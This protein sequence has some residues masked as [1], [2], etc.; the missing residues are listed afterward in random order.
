MRHTEFTTAE[1]PIIKMLEELGWEYI[2]SSELDR[3]YEEPF[4]RQTLRT[5][6]KKLNPLITSEEEVDRVI[7]ALRM[8]PN[9]ISG[10]EEFFKWIKG[11]KSLILKPGEKA[12][13]IRLIDFE[14]PEN[15]RF[16]VT[17][18]LWFQGHELV[19]F[20]IVLFINGLP[21]VVME[22]KSLTKEET[23]ET[24]PYEEALNQ[25]LRYHREAP[26]FMKYLAFVCPCNGVILKYGWDDPGKF[27]EW[28]DPKKESADP[29]KAAIQGLF[30]RKTFLDM[31]ENFIVFEKERNIIRKKIARYNQ[32]SAANQ[33][34]K[35][36]LEGKVKKGLI[37]HF[38]GS[39]KTLTMLF[40]AWKLKKIPQLS[41][42]A[43]LVVVDR[44]DLESQHLGTF[45][46]LPYTARADTRKHLREKLGRD[47]REII[48][49]TIQKFG[50]IERVLNRKENVII[51]IDEAHRSQYGALA[52]YM[53][54]ALPNAFIFGF[55]GTPIDKGPLGKSTFR[56]FGKH[57]DKY[58]MK[59]SI[60]DGATVPIYYLPKWM[61]YTTEKDR[62]E[63]DREFYKRTLGLS[64]DDQE[65][66][67][68]KSVR[69]KQILM[70]HD[71]IKKVA[72]DIAEHFK[73]NV[74]PLGFKAQ[75]VAV[76]REA[77]AL[78][79]DELDKHLPQ[80]WSV[81]IY[82]P[83]KN[84]PPFLKRFVKDQ[85]E[86]ERL[87]KEVAQGSFQRP[88]EN[89]RILIVTDMLLT[90]FD[91]PIEQ[92]MYLDKPMRDHRLLQAIA[93]TNRPYPHKLGG[94]VVDYV[95]VFE[96][97]IKVLNFHEED[98][99]DIEKA[100]CSVEEWK[101]EFKDKVSS[102]MS[103]FKDIEKKDYS[104]ST[105]F[106]AIHILEEKGKVKDFKETLSK[107]KE[108]YEN[109]A[110]DPFLVDYLPDYKWLLAVNIAYNRVRGRE[111]RLVEFR[112]KT[113][114]LVRREVKI[115]QI[116]QEIPIF[117]IDEEYLKKLDGAG[118]S[119]PQK[120]SEL[121]SA[122]SNHIRVNLERNPI[123]ETFSQRLKRIMS[124]LDRKRKR[125]EL[126]KL[127]GDIV[128]FERK[129]KELGATKLEYAMMGALKKVVRKSDEELL[130]LVKK[131]LS[132]VEGQL[133]KGWSKKKVIKVEIARRLFDACM[134]ELSG[135]KLQLNT[136]SKTS[137]E[138]LKFLERYRG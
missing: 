32:F 111:A 39:G 69:I 46:I 92:V 40:V 27:F 16:V 85:R 6:I 108:L 61:E 30:E 128:E 72:R 103:F 8:V 77:C 9:D 112:K 113:E 115:K 130:S 7:S 120:I 18:Q 59:D 34:V 52:A 21:L 82:T 137:D 126:E 80:E 118:Y 4:D 51:L 105:L 86:K 97:L 12:T 129:R 135:E 37:W 65:R 56:V 122:I 55:T 104:R 5:W 75:L 73:K 98:I 83:G 19:R 109:I 2:P 125:E 15:N 90:G 71:R 94:L 93:R 35:R 99:E 57:I 67:L 81:V 114:E 116:E 53:R 131:L 11:E 20:D 24:T 66:I 36:V 62:R 22:V 1:E 43:I 89:P 87:V 138:L 64:E 68:R 41:N 70:A 107:L 48:I 79:K 110:P 133:F 96:D 42:P 78:Y 102:L 121:S 100:V 45:K 119:E 10:N 50:G 117:R 31:I 49:T 14:N 88:G 38:Q 25:L 26:Q 136:I 91:A 84:D 3:D 132:V 23:E 17:N 76:N 74:D 13:T 33:I 47:T 134:Q 28:R 106:D 101:K 95:G 123:Y 58:S 44:K 29:V 60:R 127:V 54:R 63:L 124:L